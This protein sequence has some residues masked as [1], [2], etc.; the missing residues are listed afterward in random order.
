[1]PFL[2][3]IYSDSCRVVSFLIALSSTFNNWNSVKRS[4]LPFLTPCFQLPITIDRL[5]SFYLKSVF[6]I[7]LAIVNHFKL[8]CLLIKP[9]NFE[10]FLCFLHK[11]C[12][13]VYLVLHL[14][15]SWYHPFIQ[16]SLLL[17]VGFSIWNWDLSAGCINYFCALSLER[18]RN[19]LKNKLWVHID[20][21]ISN[22]L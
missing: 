18:T 1:M 12:P 2:A 16:G 14:F 11:R 4:F 9:I 5:S 20:S 6:M 7:H 21:V 19:V 22:S 10:Y 17:F 15:R 13:I 8:S 3:N